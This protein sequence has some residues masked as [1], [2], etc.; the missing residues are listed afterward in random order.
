MGV[1]KEESGMAYLTLIA[2]VPLDEI[3]LIRDDEQTILSP[4]MMKGVS[5]L[6]GYWI[7]LQPLGSLLALAIDG[8]ELLHE[9]FWHPLRPPMVH[10]PADVKF[11][12]DELVREWETVRENPDFHDD[13]LEAEM[14][15][16]IAV[17]THAC[18]N[19]SAVVTALDLPGDRE[20]AE[21]IRIPWQPYSQKH[22][23]AYRRWWLPW[24]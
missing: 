3:D 18:D 16:L 24:S 8:G 23:S 14:T 7:E 9:K 15:R 6:L 5:H 2:A 10:S 11:F 13:W 21:R 20:R 4:T 19:E 12:T 1:R 17:L 22:G